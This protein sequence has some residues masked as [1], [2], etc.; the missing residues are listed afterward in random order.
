MAVRRQKGEKDREQLNEY[1]DRSR[2]TAKQ[3]AEEVKKKV[4]GKKLVPH[5][6]IPKAYIYV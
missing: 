4:E 3:L 2:K 6:T 1:Y 5:P